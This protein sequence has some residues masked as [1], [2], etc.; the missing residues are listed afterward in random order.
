MQ[1]QSVSWCAWETANELSYT[2]T[3]YK[4]KNIAKEELR[5]DANIT[6]RPWR[7]DKFWKGNSTYY[8]NIDDS[9][10]FYFNIIIL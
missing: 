5:D 10:K 9:I 2:N 1:N 4:Q 3:S 7:D 6:R 8:K